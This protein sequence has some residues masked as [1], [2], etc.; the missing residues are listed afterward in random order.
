MTCAPKRLSKDGSCFQIKMCG[1]RFNTRVG[2]PLAE[3]RN[4]RPNPHF[5][6]FRD[7][8]YDHA[9]PPRAC[10]EPNP[11]YSTFDRSR[12]KTTRFFFR[13]CRR[14]MLDGLISFTCLAA[15]HAFSASVE[16]SPICSP[17]FLL[18]LDQT[19]KAGEYRRAGG[20]RSQ[21]CRSW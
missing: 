15:T 5:K 2:V 16:I 14:R 19:E 12:I 3:T 6:A 17:L 1:F 11:T 21:R 18:P 20:C 13:S 10:A 4:G 8:I 7:A 9:C